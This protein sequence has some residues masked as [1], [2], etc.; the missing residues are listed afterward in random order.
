MSRPYAATWSRAASSYRASRGSKATDP[1]RAARA[2]DP[3]RP[4]R[5]T[6]RVDAGRSRN[7]TQA[8]LEIN[9]GQRSR[10]RPSTPENDPLAFA[11]C[12]SHRASGYVNAPLCNQ[13]EQARASAFGCW[14]SLLSSI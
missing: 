8:C 14:L 5:P 4:S 12:F 2:A 13:P 9:C 6:A 3:E 11:D 1:D 10:R 7:G